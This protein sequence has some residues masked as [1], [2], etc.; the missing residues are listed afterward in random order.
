VGGR[1]GGEEEDTIVDQGNFSDAARCLRKS[2]RVCE[3]V[4]R[5]EERGREGGREEGIY[6]YIYIYIEREREREREREGASENGLNFVPGRDMQRW[7][8][9]SY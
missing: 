6:I 5:S 3:D 1:V 7:S 2:E 9:P 4:G 8:R